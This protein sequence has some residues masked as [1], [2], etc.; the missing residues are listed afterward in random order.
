MFRKYVVKNDINN[1]II[2]PMETYVALLRGINV[3]GNKKVAMADLR[4]L[5]ETAGFT[6]VR[7]YINSGN[8]I[9]SSKKSATLAATIEK[10]LLKKFG[11]SIMTMICTAENM[12]RVSQAIP[13]S[14]TNHT[15]QKTDV[16]FLAPDFDS[17]KTIKK[18]KHDP[19]IDTLIYTPGAILW[20][21]DRSQYNKSGM[22]YFFG[23]D[24]YKN[25]TARNVNSVNI[26]G[27]SENQLLR[28]DFGLAPLSRGQHAVVRPPVT[29]RSN[30]RNA[31]RIWSPVD[32]VL[33]ISQHG[34]HIDIGIYVGEDDKQE[35]FK[36]VRV[37]AE[38]LPKVTFL[39][40]DLPTEDIKPLPRGEILP[41]EKVTAG[42][43]V[44]EIRGC[45]YH[46]ARHDVNT[47]F[48]TDI[49]RVAM[50]A[51]LTELF[52]VLN[53]MRELQNDMVLLPRRGTDN[54]RRS[55]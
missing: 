48:V 4:S 10:L 2:F 52:H 28:Y 36:F 27:L 34:N 15:D 30:D 16:L 29:E 26:G 50:P 22:R 44:L 46:V 1:D 5:F 42:Q 32:G 20:N 31:G 17:K 40:K 21:I 39:L 49:S 45:A 43:L 37:N 14:W 35:Y 11:F 47:G 6:Y 33:T 7:T 23:T 55:Y 19:A 51:E 3:G 9:F 12:V 24:V 8:I 13:K 54:A 41:L 25:M 38:D 18:I 53:D